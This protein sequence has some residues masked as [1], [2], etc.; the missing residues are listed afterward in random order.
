LTG[1]EAD[2]IIGTWPSRRA[3]DTPARGQHGNGIPPDWPATV[4]GGPFS[5]R[6]RTQIA[7]PALYRVLKGEPLLGDSPAGFL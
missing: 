3:L 2:R 6:L 5:D 7:S 4:A 1:V